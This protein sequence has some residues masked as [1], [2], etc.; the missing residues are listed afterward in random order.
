MLRTDL[1]GFIM[2]IKE[3]PLVKL[4]ALIIML[5][6]LYCIASKYLSS[7]MDNSRNNFANVMILRGGAGG[8]AG[9]N[10][11]IPKIDEAIIRNH[12]SLPNRDPR[13][14]TTSMV[15]PEPTIKEEAKKQTR[16]EILNMFY[17]TLDDDVSVSSRPQGLYVI[18]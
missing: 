11:D 15:V 14:L 18:P 16:M 9:C 3:S 1:D 8:A 2:Q 10:G 6:I 4:A 5:I 17:N 12:I 13:F 7:G